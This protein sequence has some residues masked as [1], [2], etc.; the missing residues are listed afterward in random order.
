MPVAPLSPALQPSKPASDKN[1]TQPFW[2]CGLLGELPGINKDGTTTAAM[3]T[4]IDSLKK[5]NTYNGKVSY[6]NW[7]YAPQTIGG[8][9]QVLTKE[10]VFM[11][12]DYSQTFQ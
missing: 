4:L 5:T 9:R 12:E 3:Q 11:P 6:W 8:E 7:N 2:G 1:E 10:F